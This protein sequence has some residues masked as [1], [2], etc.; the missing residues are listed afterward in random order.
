MERNL[1]NQ[2]FLESSSN[3][4]KTEASTPEINREIAE[5]AF[6]ALLK[7]A[8]KINEG[9]NGIIARINIEALPEKIRDFL[10]GKQEHSDAVM[11]ILK[12]YKPGAGIH[13]YNMQTRAYEILSGD[14]TAA[15]APRPLKCLD[16]GLKN[17]QM[18]SE[19]SRLGYKES[20]ERTEILIM[21]EIHGKDLMTIICQEVIK[22]SKNIPADE[23]ENI[24]SI[25]DID[26]LIK[27]M[28][29]ALGNLPHQKGKKQTLNDLLK[30]QKIER[31]ISE[32]A[33]KFLAPTD[34]KINPAIYEKI[35]RAITLIN[36]N[37]LYH[38][39]LHLRNVM[40]A[41][42]GE[43]YIIDFGQAQT[44]PD[45][46]N[47][48]KTEVYKDEKGEPLLNDASIVESLKKLLPEH[49]TFFDH[50]KRIKGKIESTKK[51]PQT[52]EYL[53]K[54]AKSFTAGRLNSII[55]HKASDF[56]SS[57]GD[58]RIITEAL[59]LIEIAH[60]NKDVVV[61]FLENIDKH[62]K[63]KDRRLAYFKKLLPIIKK[64]EENDL[65][66]S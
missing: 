16:I 14:Q 44:F 66:A 21:D 30:N 38:R 17:A 37:R 9:A 1:K 40:V 34:F 11:K 29:F 33:L 13:E 8:K 51:W 57:H 20:K 52:I 41:D 26:Y 54:N 53:D 15:Q 46:A 43:V 3:N 61:E 60:R 36:K 64:L 56:Y 59:L 4:E 31:V 39:D 12:I 32:D 45:T 50:M 10:F 7:N 47:H 22:R 27:M 5:A 42:D 19:I 2:N 63:R 23:R 28:G 62:L 24:S 35:K 49:D 58:E 65:Q 55:Q 18:R 6:E 25:S 48:L